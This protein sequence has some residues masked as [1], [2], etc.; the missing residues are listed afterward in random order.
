MSTVLII[1]VSVYSS[2]ETSFQTQQ[3]GNEIACQNAKQLVI[4]LGAKDAKCVPY[5][6]DSKDMR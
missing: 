6:L 3:F 1:V 5:K 2:G 4:Q